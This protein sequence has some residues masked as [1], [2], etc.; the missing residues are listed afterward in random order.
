MA[1]AAFPFLGRGEG[2][3]G[4]GVGGYSRLPGRFGP[5]LSGDGNRRL[6]AKHIKPAVLSNTRARGGL[7]LRDI[8]AGRLDSCPNSIE[9]ANNENLG[10]NGQGLAL[11]GNRGRGAS[12]GVRGGRVAS[13]RK[14]AKGESRGVAYNRGGGVNSVVVRVCV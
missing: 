1:G 11:G 10:L 5:V 6:A 3:G 7:L 2:L 4:R 8:V 12:R 14:R 9:D 13:G